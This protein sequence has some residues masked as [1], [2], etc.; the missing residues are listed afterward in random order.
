M[1]K[2][3][4]FVLAIMF[5]VSGTSVYAQDNITCRDLYWFDNTNKNCDQRTFC[6]AY[7]Y[8]G[9]QT[10]ET[11][12]ACLAALGT[13]ATTTIPSVICTDTDGGQ[14]FAVK[15]TT[16]GLNPDTLQP[17]KIDDVCTLGGSLTGKCDAGDNCKVAEYYCGVDG[18]IAVNPYVCPNGCN[19][20]ACASMPPPT[21]LCQDTDGGLNYDVK[22][23]VSSPG[24]GVFTDL[25]SDANALTE[26]YC[27]NNYGSSVT[28]NCP[29][30]CKDGACLK[31][32][33]TCAGENQV[34]YNQPSMGPTECCSGFVLQPYTTPHI[35][36]A[37][38]ICVKKC[39]KEGEYTS[40]PVSPEYSFGCCSGLT[41]LDTHPGM[42]G[43]GLLCYDPNKGSPTC[44]N[45][46]TKS[47][48]WYYPNGA[49]LKYEVCGSTTQKCTDSDGGLNYYTKGYVTYEGYLLN[50][51]LPAKDY[52]DCAVGDKNIL[53]EKYCTPNGIGIADYNC[54]NGCSDGACIGEK[55]ICESTI[56]SNGCTITKCPDG[57]IST[58]CPGGYVKLGEKFNL[59]Q[60]QSVKVSDYGYMK[61][62][63]KDGIVCAA[64]SCGPTSSCVGDNCPATSCVGGGPSTCYATLTVEMPSKCATNSD[65]ECTSTATELILSEGQSKEAFG[66]TVSFLAQSG[67]GGTFIVQKGDQNQG[68]VDVSIDPSDLTIN[69]GETATYQI[70]VTDKHPI[71]ACP[72]GALCEMPAPVTYSINVQNLPFSKEYQKEV[73]LF[74]GRSEEIKLIVTPYQ[75]T[76]ESVASSDVVRSN[77]AGNAVAVPELTKVAAESASS[78]IVAQDYPQTPISIDKYKT[79]KFSVTA[80]Q[81]DNSKNQD[82]VSATLQIKP[83]TPPQPPDF[84]GEEVTIKLYKGWNMIRLPGT[85]MRFESV[86]G[87]SMK[88]QG[89]VY[90]KGKFVTMNEA[91]TLLGDQFREYLSK[92]AFWVYSPENV[93]LKVKVDTQVSFN[94]IGLNAGWN[95][96]PITE[97]MVGGYLRDVKGSCTFDKMYLWN[98]ISQSWQ[99]IDESYTFHESDMNYGIL[100]KT[101]EDCVLGGGD[102]TITPPSMPE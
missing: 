96:V 26:Y 69:Y 46:G 64:A 99:K 71:P 85:L 54:P 48:G 63:L 8:Y 86:E 65:A 40:G 36:E 25:C 42:T 37:D 11:R 102:V 58:T 6:G 4:I 84:P 47:E 18:K 94:G 56:D 68:Y 81:R 27:Y 95:L 82:T 14:N 87:S 51:G 88:L 15:G 34:V 31:E 101:G 3:I 53:Q 98:P 9:L 52:D 93:A 13:V 7:M 83:I 59:A 60:A 24:G 1:R 17:T 89:F 19:D 39:A 62:T 49:L 55:P 20:G 57:T 72:A 30:G 38:G 75:M 10:F 33:T 74:A 77:V 23:T 43:G 80:Y 44:K 50:N 41:A 79:Y 100:I 12:D 29:N 21:Q 90:Y 45:Q 73:T 2:I 92:H 22:G 5:L 76:T 67:N 91:E 35:P 32:P 78:Q 61:I 70:K 16:A 28:Y 66:A 97:D